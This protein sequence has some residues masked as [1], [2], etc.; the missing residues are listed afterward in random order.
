M[1]GDSDSGDEVGPQFDVEKV[2]KIQ[3]SKVTLRGW[4]PGGEQVGGGN[5]TSPARGRL[6]GREAFGWSRLVGCSR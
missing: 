1:E 4:H 6:S 3:E 5:K 2:R